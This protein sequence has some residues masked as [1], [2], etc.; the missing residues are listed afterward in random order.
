[1]ADNICEL[2]KK[3]GEGFTK[4]EWLKMS[5][6]GTLYDYIERKDEN[7]VRPDREETDNGTDNDSEIFRRD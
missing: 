5:L 4:V 2:Y 3:Y 6:D 7:Y 1:M